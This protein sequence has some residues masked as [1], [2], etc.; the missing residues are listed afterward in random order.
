MET[1]VAAIRPRRKFH[2]SFPITSV[3]QT[4]MACCAASISSGVLKGMNS[5]FVATIGDEIWSFFETH[6]AHGAACIHMALSR[7][8]VGLFA[9]CLSAAIQ[10]NAASKKKQFQCALSAFPK[11][12]ESQNRL[13]TRRL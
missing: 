6:P 1:L 5:S 2:P 8:A 4:C 12:F 9:Q 3:G 11:Q 7:R 13:T 10:V